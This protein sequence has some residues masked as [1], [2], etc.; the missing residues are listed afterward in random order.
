MPPLTPPF[1]LCV[2]VCMSLVDQTSPDGA[3][4]LRL[5]GLVLMRYDA[6]LM[7]GACGAGA[8]ADADDAVPETLELSTGRVGA[9]APMGGHGW[10]QEGR[11]GDRGLVAGSFV[12]ERC[13]DRVGS[14]GLRIDAEMDEHSWPSCSVSLSGTSRASSMSIPDSMGRSWQAQGWRWAPSDDGKNVEGETLGR[15]KK[16]TLDTA[17]RLQAG[18]LGALSLHRHEVLS[19]PEYVCSGRWQ[20]QSPCCLVA[21]FAARGSQRLV[22]AGVSLVWAA[23]IFPKSGACGAVAARDLCQ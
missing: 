7:H 6:A 16:W 15:C 3:R 4:L 1:C 8:G 12:G 20:A 2:H 14:G 11:R 18:S 5:P 19:H 17:H 13:C 23:G 22:F 10:Q 9:Y 21:A